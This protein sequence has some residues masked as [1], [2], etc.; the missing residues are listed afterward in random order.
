MG[1]R[2]RRSFLAFIAVLVVVS[3]AAPA[4]ANPD[5]TEAANAPVVFDVLIMRPLG[6]ATLAIGAGVFVVTAPLVLITR[7]TDIGVSADRL[8]MNPVRFLWMDPLGGH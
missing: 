2:I 5:R 6:F 4:I 3:L 1:H 7:P 8:V